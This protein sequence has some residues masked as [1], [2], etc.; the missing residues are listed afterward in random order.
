MVP[1]LVSRGSRGRGEGKIVGIRGDREHG[2]QLT[3]QG[4]NGLT[5]TDMASTGPSGVCTWPSVYMV[6]ILAW[7]LLVCLFGLIWFVL[8]FL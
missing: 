6:W 5:K 8:A 1:L 4:S 2:P 7:L 3:M